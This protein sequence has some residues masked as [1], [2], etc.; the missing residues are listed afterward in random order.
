[1]I[2]EFRTSKLM[3]NLRSWDRK[4]YIIP[5]MTKGGRYLERPAFGIT[6]IRADK[7]L[8]EA[9]VKVLPRVL[10]YLELMPHLYRPATEEDV[11]EYYSKR[12]SSKTKAREMADN[13]LSKLT[14][15]STEML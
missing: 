5:I 11:R 2:E 8:M 1:L 15:V 3:D 6:Q 12:T 14:L 7:L 4:G 10:I 13:A 9:E